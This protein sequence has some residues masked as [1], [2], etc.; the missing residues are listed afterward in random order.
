MEVSLYEKL[1]SKILTFAL[2]G[3]LL[4]CLPIILILAFVHLVTW[5]DLFA[6]C[7]ITPVSIGILYYIYKR[8]HTSSNGKFYISAVSFFI[9][10]VFLWYIPTGQI[11]GALILYMLLSLIYLDA[12]VILFATGYAIVI[13]TIYVFFNPFYQGRSV[14]DS[15]VIYIIISMI[16]IV[17]Y[18][19]TLM[20]KKMLEDVK[21]NEGKVTALL[22]EIT[23]SISAIEQFGKNL[24]ENVAHTTDISKEISFGYS[25]IAKGVEMQAAGILDINERVSGTNNFIL[26]VAENSKVLKELSLSTSTVTQKGNEMLQ[27]LQSDLN[28]VFQ[29]QEESEHSMKVLEE[30]TDK[31]SGILKAIDT[32]AEQT[33]LLALNASIEAARAG[34]HGKSFA[35]V[36]NEIRKLAGHAGSS[37]KEISSIVG[38]IQMQTEAVSSQIEKGNQAIEQSQVAA[39]TSKE[40]FN[41]ITDNMDNV[42]T[43][44]TD[45]QLMLS[46][47]EMNSQAIGHELANI[48]N[49]TE[50]SSASIEQMSASMTVQTGQIEDISTSFKDLEKMI[51]TLNTITKSE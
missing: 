49:V 25:E 23:V 22:Q 4:A 12:R 48:S 43:K 47:L 29:I 16:G 9:A 36:A 50:E 30:K 39:N 17:A 45:I 28:R 8:T 19:I 46:D 5:S 6:L 34:E 27:T 1:S 20:G 11:W 38:D 13:N 44:A 31:I 3:L 51:D 15:I 21:E 10:S 42:L 37:S 24:Y 18:C 26:G 41:A 14:L 35:V 33:N 32:I 7:I 2:I 40:L